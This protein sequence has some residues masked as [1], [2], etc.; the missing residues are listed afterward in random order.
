MFQLYRDV[1]VLAVKR[2]RQS[3]L[4]ALSIPIYGAILMVAS[5]IVAPLGSFVGGI[6]VGLLALACFAGY[7]Y[8]L[9]DAVSGSK[10]RFADIKRGMRGM[11]DLCNAAF[12]LM[13]IGF[14]VGIIAAAAGPKSQAIQAIALLAMA[15][16]LNVLPEL[17]YTSRSGSFA[18]LRESA[19]FVMQNP[20]A[21]FLPNL[22]FA[23]I[24]LAATGPLMLHEPGEFLMQLASLASPGAVGRMVRGAPLWAAPIL[25]VFFHFIMVFR[26]L[27]FRELSTGN[28]RLRRFKAQF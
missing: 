21:W 13:I 15:F 6:L 2:T 11:W 27:L 23:V 9:S 16:F 26:G 28:A 1:L 25:I 10:I 19:D 17:I 5:F 8:L 20:F 22:V 3:W 18:L 7:L 24:I 14:G 12:A 4:A